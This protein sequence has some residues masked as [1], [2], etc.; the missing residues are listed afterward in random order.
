MNAAEIATM[1]RLRGFI[2]AQRCRMTPFGQ[3]LADDMLAELNEH[4][5][6]KSVRLMTVYFDEPPSPRGL[7]RLMGDVFGSANAATN[8]KPA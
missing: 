7:D 3:C 2:K 6:P 5:A 8:R 4:L 1:Q